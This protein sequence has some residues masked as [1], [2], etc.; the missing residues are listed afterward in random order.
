MNVPAPQEG[1]LRDT[2]DWYEGR[3]PLSV[4]DPFL[5]DALK[6]R[7]GRRVLDLGCR[8]GGYAATLAR[9]GFECSAIDI[10]PVYVTAARGLGVQATIFD[11]LRIPFA[12]GAFD[13]VFAIEVLEHVSDPAPLIREVRRVTRGNFVATVPNCTQKTTNAQVVFEHMLDVDHKNFF[14]SASLA[15]LLRTSFESVEVNEVAPID[16]ALARLILPRPVARLHGLA[17]RAGFLR[18]RLYFRLLADCR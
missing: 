3:D 12:D 7:C 13:S 8:L 16:R 11:G 15:E 18:P 9:D 10:N 14:T 6:R 2:R 4:V 5:I 1:A 17:I